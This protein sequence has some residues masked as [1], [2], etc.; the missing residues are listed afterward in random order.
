MHFSRQ[1]SSNIYCRDSGLARLVLERSSPL[2]T[3]RGAALAARIAGYLDCPCRAPIKS[4]LRAPEAHT[5]AGSKN[6][7]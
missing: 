6:D 5:R 4:A 3:W 2:K 1:D 7:P